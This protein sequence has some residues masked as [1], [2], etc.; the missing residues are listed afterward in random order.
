LRIFEAVNL[1]RDRLREQIA[2]LFQSLIAANQLQSGTQLPSERELARLLGVSRH[3]VREAMGVL[4][5]RGITVM[6]AGSG[7]Y[8]TDLQPSTIT[9]SI[10]RYFALGSCTYRDWVELREIL[11]PEEAAMAAR[12]ATA[13][14]LSRLKDLVDRLEQPFDPNDV[15]AHSAVDSEFHEMI[16]IAAHNGLVAAIVAALQKV[17]KS[18]IQAQTE[19]LWLPGGSASHRPVYEAIAAHDPE[20]ARMAMRVHLGFLR[21]MMASSVDENSLLRNTDPAEPKERHRWESKRWWK[22]G[23]A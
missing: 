8:V 21:V 16:A 13:E 15:D 17:T 12:S 23:R 7:T 4:I 22:I 18:L 9:E 1:R 20:R 11:E 10:G 2:D 5:E 3:T 14:E 19:A 6:K